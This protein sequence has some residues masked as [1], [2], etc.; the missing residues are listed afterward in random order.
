M[1]NWP[2]TLTS[3]KV[4][5]QNKKMTGVQDVFLPDFSNNFWRKM[6]LLSY[7]I[8]WPNFITWLPLLLEML[9][10][11][12]CI[13]LLSSRKLTLAILSSRFSYKTKNQDNLKRYLRFR[14]ITS[15]NLSYKARV[16][17]FFYF[18]EKFCSVLKIIKF[19]YF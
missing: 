6:F 11:V 14:M 10:N 13:C 18:V 3:Y 8:D 2:L 9:E 12:Y 15:Q 5:L 16:K 4:L 19:L 1:L 7:S 17:N